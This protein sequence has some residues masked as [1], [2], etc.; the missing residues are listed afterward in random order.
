[1]S[2]S[3]VHGNSE[4]IIHSILTC[5]LEDFILINYIYEGVSCKHVT[6]WG[7][8]QIIDDGNHQRGNQVILDNMQ[9]GAL[10]S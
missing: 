6:K 9:I 1:M 10:V 8:S 3:S 4:L 5:N 7:N 2:A